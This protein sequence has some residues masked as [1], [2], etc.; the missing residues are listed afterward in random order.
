MV[1]EMQLKHTLKRIPQAS[2]TPSE[3]FVGGPSA[4]LSAEFSN[5]GRKD[6]L[7]CGRMDIYVHCAYW[8]I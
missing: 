7:V 5:S 6:G 3:S 2:G 4:S 1:E 8:N